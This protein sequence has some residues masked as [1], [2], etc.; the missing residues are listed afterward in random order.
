MA[1]IPQ[2]QSNEWVFIT[3]TP[4]RPRPTKVQRS[5]MRRR[6]M[7]EIG[8]TRRNV[9]TTLFQSPSISSCTSSDTT[10]SDSGSSPSPV[11]HQYGSSQSPQYPTSSTHIPSFLASPIVL[12]RESQRLLHHMFSDAIP[13]QFQIYKDR[14]YPICIANSAAFDQMLATYATHISQYHMQH[15]MKHFI[16][17]NHTKAL[18]RVRNDI[19]AMPL[20]RKRILEGTLSAIT[21]LACY[22]HLQR[23]MVSWRSHMAAVARLIHESGLSLGALDEKLVTVVKWVDLIGSYALDIAPALGN[24]N[25]EVDYIHCPSKTMSQCLN[26]LDLP[27][28][29]LSAFQT[30][31]WTNTQIIPQVSIWSNPVEVDRL[32]H[33]LT[34]RFLSLRND[35]YIFGPVCSGL[36]S[37]ALLYLAE[38]RR[39]SGI[40]P[41][42][43]EMHVR[44][45]RLSME[46]LS[47]TS[48]PS[49]LTLWLLTVGALEATATSDR[50]FFHSRLLLL[51]Q[52]LEIR[53]VLCWT[54]R[55]E[56]LVW[57]DAVFDHKLDIT[58][59]L[60]QG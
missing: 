17:S 35:A 5:Q 47:P 30:L 10:A 42:V 33:P 26:S 57:S 60:L 23:D 27:A 6:V 14:W 29:L 15:N 9:Q 54:Q 59:G 31:Q 2:H 56:R 49:E 46:A 53:S 58:W 24:V 1:P 18:A 55:L 50:E 13:S 37:G 52:A 45:L 34:H 43:T 40:S 4:T 16:L 25:G 38:F 39:M 36:R 20:G 48:V 19:S 7:R 3:T 22:S 11:D 8:Y 32:I 28:P 51:S 12:D 21:A 44:Q 41:V